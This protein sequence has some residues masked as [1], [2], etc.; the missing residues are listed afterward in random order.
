MTDPGPDQQ[1]EQLA[2]KVA[3]LVATHKEQVAVYRCWG[4]EPQD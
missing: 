4:E 2:K 1:R 3:E